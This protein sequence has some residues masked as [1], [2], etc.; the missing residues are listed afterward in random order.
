MPKTKRASESLSE[1]KR[2]FLARLKLGELLRTRREDAGLTQAAVALAAGWTQGYY[3]ELENGVKSSPDMVRWLK[4]ADVLQLK[5][6]L[7]LTVVGQTRG[8]LAL[9]LP[10]AGDHRRD[11]LLDLAVEQFSSGEPLP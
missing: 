1:K 3:A 2:R 6:K 5:R 7:F 11:A 4:V 9:L 10:R 8:E